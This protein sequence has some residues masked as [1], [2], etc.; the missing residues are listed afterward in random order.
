MECTVPENVCLI[1]CKQSFHGYDL[2]L[3]MPLSVAQFYI[4]IPEGFPDPSHQSWS[5]RQVQALISL[6]Y[7]F[8]FWINVMCNEKGL[9][10]L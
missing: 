2:I 7:S 10:E 6:V 9:T 4:Q 8:M 1:Y 5:I 3:A